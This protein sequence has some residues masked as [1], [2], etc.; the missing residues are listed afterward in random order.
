MDKIREFSDYQEKSKVTDIN[1]KEDKNFNYN[2]TRYVL[3]LVGESGEFAEKVKKAL[4]DNDGIIDRPRK[5]EMKKEL[6][7]VLWYLSQLA[8][9]L[10]LSL[11]EVA[12]A[13]IE[14]LYS[15]LDRKKLRGSGD[16]R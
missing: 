7:D 12:T 9:K 13:N 11:E 8:T 3:G 16:N 2:I 10:G 4:R 5:E 14:K 1:Q 15:R 6:G